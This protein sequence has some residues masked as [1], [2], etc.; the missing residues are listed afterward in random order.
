MKFV[1]EK[2]KT[3]KIVSPRKSIFSMIIFSILKQSCNTLRALFYKHQ[4]N[5]VQL[6]IWLGNFKNEPQNELMISH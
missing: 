5:S 4:I 1:Y 3:Y 6:Q 2:M